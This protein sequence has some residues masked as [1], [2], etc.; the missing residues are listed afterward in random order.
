[1]YKSLNL[2]E[3][4]IWGGKWV[5]NFFISRFCKQIRKK[6]TR[7]SPSRDVFQSIKK[8]AQTNTCLIGKRSPEIWLPRSFQTPIKSYNYTQEKPSKIDWNLCSSRISEQLLRGKSL[9]KIYVLMKMHDE[10]HSSPSLSSF[11]LRKPPILSD[12]LIPAL[13]REWA[14]QKRD[15]SPYWTWICWL[16]H[17]TRLREMGFL[18]TG[19][20][21]S[22]IARPDSGL[23]F[24][25]EIR[26]IGGTS[27][28]GF[29][30]FR[31]LW[32]FLKSG[33]VNPPTNPRTG[34]LGFRSQTQ[35]SGW[36]SEGHWMWKFDKSSR[37]LGSVELEN[38][39]IWFESEI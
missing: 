24:N 36:A 26:G 32:G 6:L 15:Q 5:H 17:Q 1:M 2:W 33:V 37:A 30:Y 3:N 8:H 14:L 21:I 39:F 10:N 34:H 20:W 16:D 27:M 28:H 31:M 35:H 25:S 7:K 38:W 9:G 18:P 29:R 22:T 13:A 12:L 19:A 11:N 23:D 4:V